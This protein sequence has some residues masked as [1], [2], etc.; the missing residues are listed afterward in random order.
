VTFSN[1]T[2]VVAGAPIR[3]SIERL[4]ELLAQFSMHP[5]DLLSLNGLHRLLR[6]ARGGRTT[7]GEP[8]LRRISSA[9]AGRLHG[10]TVV[11]MRQVEVELGDEGFSCEGERFLF[12]TI[13]DQVLAPAPGSNLFNQLTVKRPESSE[14][15]DYHFE[16]KHA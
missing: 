1:V 12:A 16:P 5:R 13:I 6:E 10:Q 8:D 9:L 2:G 14:G 15:Q 4:W 11:P 3:L 7:R